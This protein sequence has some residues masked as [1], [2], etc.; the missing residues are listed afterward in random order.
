M[1][2]P[3]RGFRTPLSRPPPLVIWSLCVLEGRSGSTEFRRTPGDLLWVPRHYRW[4]IDFR[5]NVQQ[6]I[7]PPRRRRYLYQ[8]SAPDRRGTIAEVAVQEGRLLE[9]E[10]PNEDGSRPS[11]ETRSPLPR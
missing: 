8:R 10:H 11:T 6:G 2:K 5:G 7:Q 1:T 4:L 9:K 3:W